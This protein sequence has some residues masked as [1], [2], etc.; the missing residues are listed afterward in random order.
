M[1]YKKKSWREKM[2]DKEGLPKVLRL[3]AGFPC[4]KPLAK[5]GVQAGDQVVLVNPGEVAEIMRGVPRGRLITIR[6]VC[7]RLAKK[8]GVSGCCTLTT[9]I[10]IMTAANAAEEM[11]RAGKKS[12]LPFWRTLKA[13]G[14][15]NEKYP[16]G[17]EAHKKLLE[18]EGF[19]VV[20]RGKK[21]QV[22]DFGRFL[23]QETVAGK[24]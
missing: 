5:M 16:G 12:D 11:A 24:E 23:L 20:R 6:D 15:L 10:F 8:H 14:F 19:T 22:L 17:A 7:R 13:D 9:G 3:A 2:A 21:Y 4:Y 18:E 1:T